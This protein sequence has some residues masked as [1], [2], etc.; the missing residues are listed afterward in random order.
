VWQ[1]VYHG[2]KVKPGFWKRD[3]ATLP[4]PP[5]PKVKGA[6]Q[7]AG[8]RLLEL[9]ALQQLLASGNFDLD[10]L[11]LANPKTRK[12]VGERLGWE[13]PQVLQAL[14]LLKEPAAKTKGAVEDQNDYVKSEWCEV[15]A[16]VG[17]RWVACDVYR[18][19]I[20]LVTLQRHRGG[21]EMYF[22]F[23]VEDDGS[24]TIVMAS[25]HPS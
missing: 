18:M 22:K 10:G 24:I 19:T 17:K 12:D 25:C 14:L 21:I 15:D 1:C 4:P 3:P 8:G 23:S 20:D 11:W 9:T 6:R 7:I 16:E 13:H 5:P 2:D